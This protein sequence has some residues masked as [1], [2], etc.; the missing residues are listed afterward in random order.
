[1]AILITLQGP[2]AGRKYPL[3][4]PHAVLGRQADCT[5][6]LPP[7]AVSRQHAQITQADNTY[8]IED[9]GSSNG[10][11]VNGT[12]LN[13]HV[14]VR[15]T[16]QD[17]FQIGPYLFGLRPAPVVANTEQSLVIREQLSVLQVHQSVYGQDPAQKLQVVVEIG[18]HL[19]RTLD[20]EELLTR[21]LDQLIRLF[22]QADRA[23]AL[24]C[25]GDRLVVRGQ[26][27]RH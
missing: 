1:M 19:A 6:C 15:L 7:K 24:L 8:F 2:D 13:P 21:L 25:E 4:G 9:L 5:V 23:M 12:R 3:E 27:C 11:F 17:T 14:R 18:Q 20:P 16:E 26:R 22:P 10:T